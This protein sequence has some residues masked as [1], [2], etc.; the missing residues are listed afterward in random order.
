MWLPA[1][2]HPGQLTC[3]FKVIM[4]QSARTAATRCAA[5]VRRK[6]LMSPQLQSAYRHCMQRVEHAA[7]RPGRHAP[8][9]LLLTQAYK[10]TAVVS[11]ASSHAR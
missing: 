5:M 1:V 3:T 4:H 9:H 8:C 2:P 6:E 10:S 7:A 11:L